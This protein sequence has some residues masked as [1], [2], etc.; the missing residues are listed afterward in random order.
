[1]WVL[2]LLAQ[3]G[4]L[5]LY[6]TALGWQISF[7][8]LVQFVLSYIICRMP[9]IVTHTA[10][11]QSSGLCA[12]GACA[13]SLCHFR[14]LDSSKLSHDVRLLTFKDRGPWRARISPAIRKRI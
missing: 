9:R 4:N 11:Q 3:T 14:N 7:Q 8:A 13:D 2:F 12:Y 6:L 5:A 1:M 10:R